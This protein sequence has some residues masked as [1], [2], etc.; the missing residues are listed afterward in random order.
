MTEAITTYLDQQQLPLPFCP[1]CGHASILKALDRALVKLQLKPENVV[2]VTDIGCVGLSDKFFITQAFHGLHGRSITYASGLA[3]AQPSKNIIVLIGDGGIGIGGHHLINAARRNM[4]LSVL[5]FNNFNY[6][7]TGGEHSV[8]TPAGG[9]TATTL[10]GQIEQPMDICATAA[11]NGGSFIA[12]TTSFDNDLSEVISEAITHPGFSLVDIWELCT[13]YYAVKNKFGKKTIEET[14]ERLSLET[15]ILQKNEVKSFYTSYMEKASAVQK[16][17]STHDHRIEISHASQLE[18]AVKISLAGA[19]GEKIISAARAFGQGAVRS[20][21]YVSQRDDYPVTVKTGH[22]L[23][24]VILSPSPIKYTGK[25]IPD[26]LIILFKEGLQKVAGL[27]PALTSEQ[28]VYLNA[29][30]GEI[31]TAARVRLLNFQHSGALHRRKEAYAVVALAAVLNEEDWY[32]VEAYQ[33]A[34]LSRKRFA[35][36]YTA[37][38]D[39][40]KRVLEP[41]NG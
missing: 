20:G 27:L 6:G 14:L 24:E 18:Q 3:L 1:G 19:A 5:V 39:A 10:V 34:L 38:L 8:T 12:R 33:A 37:A 9:L 22:S 23:A 25:R 17:A 21:L 32:P 26:V 31:N 15:G 2:L 11:V 36:Q 41:T 13:S 29:E 28:C 30:L 7:M 16:A 40:A 35:K 4:N